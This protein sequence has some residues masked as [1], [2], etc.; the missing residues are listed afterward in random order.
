MYFNFLKEGFFVL[1]ERH[2]KLTILI[3]FKTVSREHGETN[4]LPR[5]LG[6]FLFP[7]GDF[8]RPDVTPVLVLM[9]ENEGR[10]IDG[11][12]RRGGGRGRR[13]IGRFGGIQK[14]DVNDIELLHANVESFQLTI[15][16]V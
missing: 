12:G 15:V 5:P 4:L 9:D 16:S 11:S 6:E 14:G 3:S 1:T 2:S 10:G 8:V 7:Q 13:H